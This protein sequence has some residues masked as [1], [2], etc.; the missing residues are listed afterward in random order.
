MSAK[1]KKK[2]KM[3]PIEIG[4]TD[5]LDFVSRMRQIALKNLDTSWL[6]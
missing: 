3:S 4:R 1:K 5:S 6:M 2:K